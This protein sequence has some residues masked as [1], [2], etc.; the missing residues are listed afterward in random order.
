MAELTRVLK[1]G[2]KLVS[3]EFGLP[4]G[5]WRLLWNAYTR[6]VLPTVGRWI[7]PGWAAV[8]RFLGGSIERYVRTTPTQAVLRWWRD[9]GVPAP[10]VRRLSLGGVVVIWGEKN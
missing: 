6:L 3:L 7:S 5:A 2:G 8:G 4:R 9:A 10:R 1:P